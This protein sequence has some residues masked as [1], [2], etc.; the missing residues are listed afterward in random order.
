MEISIYISFLT[1]KAVNFS[2]CTCLPNL[3]VMGLMEMQISIFI[4]ILTQKAELT[5]SVRWCTCLPNLVV[6]CLMEIEI[7]IFISVLT[8]KA[9]LTTSVR[10]CTCFFN[11]IAGLRPDDTK[12]VSHSI[13]QIFLYK[14]APLLHDLALPRVDWDFSLSSNLARL[15]DYTMWL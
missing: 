8:Q 1:Q 10:W 6:I 7:S 5:T 12:K 13:W 15:R 9:E 3:V 4:S 2:R 14:T 11:K